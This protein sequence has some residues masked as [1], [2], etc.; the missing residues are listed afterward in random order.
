MGPINPDL[1]V[2]G[3]SILTAVGVIAFAIQK[4][5]KAWSID[6]G[7]I[8]KLDIDTSLFQR[9]NAELERLDELNKEYTSEIKILREQ[10]LELQREFEN[11]KIESSSKNVLISN[12]NRHVAECEQQLDKLIADNNFLK[13]AIAGIKNV[14]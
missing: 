6:R 4:A 7:D 14:S 1:L 12:M 13:T 5:V 11:F 9:M 2:N 8:Q 3:T 10:Y